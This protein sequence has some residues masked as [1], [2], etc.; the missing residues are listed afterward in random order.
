MPKRKAPPGGVHSHRYGKQPRL[1][2]DTSETPELDILD[3]ELAMLTPE[4]IT[5]QKSIVSQKLH[6][7]VKVVTRALKVG[8]GFER[9][10]SGKKLKAAREGGDAVLVER[11]EREIGVLKEVELEGI[12]KGAVRKGLGKGVKVWEFFPM[13][14]W[15][16]K[17]GEKG[18]GKV[19]S[20]V[21]GEEAAEVR[22]AR[23][24]VVAGLCNMKP[25][26]EAV[27]A[28]VEMVRQVAVSRWRPGVEDKHEGKEEEEEEEQEQLEDGDETGE[29]NEGD[30]TEGEW[31]EWNGIEDTPKISTLGNENNDK[32]GKTNTSKPS[33]KVDI[34]LIDPSRGADEE[35]SGEE[36]DDDTHNINSEE[37]DDEEA[38][39]SE[40]EE[41]DLDEDLSEEE[42]IERLG[43]FIAPGS[44]SEEEEEESQA[45]NSKSD[46][47]SAEEE[48][49]KPATKKS[50]PLPIKKQK[51]TPHT[52]SRTPSRSPSP[53]P[54]ISNK[55]KPILTT[56]STFL[57]TLMSGYISG[58]ES[59][60]DPFHPN[61]S[62]PAQKKERKNRM[63]QQARRALAEKKFKENARHIKLG[64]GSGK[65]EDK[66]DHR[67][68]A[69]TRGGGFQ[70]GGGRF[71][72]SGDGAGPG[73]GRK[74]VVE[75]K[76]DVDGP[77]H[78]SWEAA[79]K[80]KEA[81]AKAEFQGKK[82]KFD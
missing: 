76:K 66:G 1:A 79:R 44:D 11:V 33:I 78:P 82:I 17:A 56:K 45:E 13:E 75:R 80:A 73:F 31:S 37:E 8:R 19:S 22:K 77:L 14:E 69:S 53:A 10:R 21:D 41:P 16:E 12:A 54:Q 42:I 38:S 48:P 52:P 34:S 62:G 26:R 67:R 43:K 30:E 57:P 32:S 74:Q 81:K 15:V 23:S 36:D 24:N 25:V 35:W 5:H 6:H 71:G 49:R 46:N 59:D 7:A 29:E 70:K 55:P 3:T 61:K 51:T 27:R 64:L 28:A 47:S 4:Q 20:E 2:S 9:Q 60:G 63:G 65:K 72:A 58:S 18:E 68:G 39:K 40:E 50:K